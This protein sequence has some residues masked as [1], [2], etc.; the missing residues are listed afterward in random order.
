[1]LSVLTDIRHA[2]RG[3]RKSP[4]LA[5]VAIGSLALGIGAN[6]TIYSVV[7]EMILDDLSARQ[8]GRLVRVSAQVSC[9]QYRDL[10]HAGAFQDLA[11]DSGLWNVNWDVRQHSEVLWEMMTSPNF[12]DVLGVRASAGRLYSQSDEGRQVAVV[13]YGFWRER[14]LSDPNVIGRALQ[15]NG[16][17]YT[18]LGV[19]PRDYRSIMGHGV[20]PEVYRLAPHDFLECH[21]FGRLRDGFTREQ[22]RQALVATARV[23][24]GQ[25]F[26]KQISFLRPMAGLAAH[27]AS[28][29]DDRRYFVFFAMLFATA[30]ILAVIACFNVAG[31]L[32]ARGVTRQRELAICKALG[33]SRLQLT[34]HLL[35]EGFV[36]VLL[37]AGAGLVV[38][39]FLR[40]RLSYVR[41]PSAYNLPFEFH[42]QNDRGLF[43]YALAAALT[44]LL[45]SSLVPSLRGS[46]ADIGLA[47]KQGEPAF[48]IRRWNLR[49][50]FVAVQLAL[51]MVL[52][53]LGVL[54]LRS[55]VQVARV[56]AGFDVSHTIIALVAPLPEIHKGEKGWGW[57][58]GLV[59]RMKEVPGVLGVTSIGPL[60]LMGELPQDPVRRKGDP[61]STARDSYSVLAGEQFGKVLGI[62]IL[63]G[64][65]FEIADR[66]RQPV[67]ALINQTLARRLFGAANPIGSQILAGREHERVLEVIGVAADAKMRTLGEDHVAVFF[68][69]VADSQ[70][71][72]RVAGNPAQWIQPLRSAL[73]ETDPASAIDV[74]PLSDA[75]AGA[76]FPMRVAAGFVGTLSGLG[77]LLVLTGLYSSI[78]YATRRRTRELAIRAAV[79]APRST[80]LWTAIKDGMTVLA[81]GVAVGLP[82]AV[83]AI[84][85][86]TDILPAGVD[87]WNPV[88]FS[89]VAVILLATGAA[90]AWIPARDAANVDPSL[91]LRQ[92]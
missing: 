50:T 20:S 5:V 33:A 29:G 43:M 70:M 21:P 52:L 23:I 51:S 45:V 22:T 35:A 60:P 86:L 46:N 67:P 57:R 64:R 83:A 59:R 85:P 56:D 42:F 78:S 55:F 92:E 72:V 49:N 71:L 16:Q 74:Q 26:A 24:G 37:G 48:S 87:P 89:V 81:C 2:A 1:M 40:N 66:S 65:D 41:W 39:S 82:L 63:R 54:F 34:R 31:L 47:M 88:M 17:L 77:L 36:L 27:A 6:V 28:E 69:P 68:T 10:R 80:I 84:R 9:G 58:D 8:P 12:F 14:L 62:S 53:T 75:A 38:D 79:G 3:L 19:L 90:A 73:A 18:V 61:L 15:F 30:V 44:A 7:R 76:I 32:L 25:D 91:A 4:A 13:S 11:F